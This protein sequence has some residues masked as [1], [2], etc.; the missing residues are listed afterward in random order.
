MDV[1]DIREACIPVAAKLG[2]SLEVSVLSDARGSTPIQYIHSSTAASN[3][4]VEVQVPTASSSPS[5]PRDVKG[6]R[7]QSSTSTC[8]IE[9]MDG[10]D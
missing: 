1:W 10:V 3:G 5:Q 9:D 2:Q 4:I 8:A 6:G 7:L